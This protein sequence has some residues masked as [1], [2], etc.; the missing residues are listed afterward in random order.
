MLTA[1]E[2]SAT[3]VSAAAGAMP[4]LQAAAGAAVGSAHVTWSNTS[5]M[6][7][8]LAY[9]GSNVSRT[10]TFWGQTA[11][12]RDF[13][14]LTPGGTYQFKVRARYTG[15]TSN[16]SAWVSTTLPKLVIVSPTIPPTTVAPTTV[17]PTTVAPTTVAPTTVAPTTVAPTTVAPTTVAPTTVAPTTTAVAPAFHIALDPSGNTTGWVTETTGT[18]TIAKLNG[19]FQST[20]G[21]WAN[22]T[23]YARIKRKLPEV[24]RVVLSGA[25]TMTEVVELPSDFYTQQESYVRFMNTDNYPAK[26]PLTGATVGALSASGW[27]V[28]FLVYRSDQLPRLESDHD[29]HSKLTLWTGTSRLPVGVNTITVRFTPSQGNQG[30]FEVWV[31]GVKVGS[32][33]GMQTVP[34]TLA[35]SEA[36]ITR[37]VAG[38]DG[39]AQQ[40]TKQMSVRLHSFEFTAH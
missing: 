21:G 30:S 9:S 12:S 40:S 2:F 29:G 15:Q 20:V 14:G 39:A 7:Y 32:G 36:V 22:V 24:D 26:S 16:W 13:S 35:P 37:I 10:R 38:M 33:S 27:R 19:Y 11:T 6:S 17:A 18:D 1:H 4:V 5:A 23:H 3:S 8:D 28:G 25:F 31:N 34:A